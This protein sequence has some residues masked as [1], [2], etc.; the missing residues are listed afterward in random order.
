APRRA[1][2][3]PRPPPEIP[4]LAARGL[5]LNAAP[6][7][8]GEIAAVVVAVKPQTAPEAMPAVAPLVGAASVVVSIMAGRTLGFL[9][10]ALPRAPPVRA[11]PHTPAAIGRGITVAL[12]HPRLAPRHRPPLDPLPS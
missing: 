11:M 6:N 12:S 8:V 9:E 10:A 1:V 2:I 3:E 4:A 5:R 7:A